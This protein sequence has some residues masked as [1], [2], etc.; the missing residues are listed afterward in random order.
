MRS[1]LDDCSDFHG[2]L[3]MTIGRIGGWIFEEYLD[4]ED[5]NGFARHDLLGR[6]KLGLWNEVSLKRLGKWLKRLCEAFWG[7]MKV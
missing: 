3:Q 6:K 5:W 2:S 7:R 1:W 4:L